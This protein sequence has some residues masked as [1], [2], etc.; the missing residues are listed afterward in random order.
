V[1][2]VEDSG[3]GIDA[4]F[5]PH[6]FD[7]FS[8]EDSSSIRVHGGLGLGLAIVRDLVQLHGGTVEVESLGDKRGATFTV[9]LP[10]KSDQKMS[11]QKEK[12]FRSPVNIGNKAVRLDGIRVLIVD[13]EANAREASIELLTFHGAEVK[14][15]S[16]A[17]E[18]F[19][20]FN[21]FKPHIL[22]SDIAMPGEDGYSLIKKVRALSKV[23]GGNTPAVA[24]TAYAGQEDSHQAL[25]AGFQ[26][27]LS[28]PVDGDDFVNSIAKLVGKNIH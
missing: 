18:G 20:V 25:S 5:L 9:M 1:I 24:M 17:K 26:L 2:R 6:I 12:A 11:A 14:S 10:I 13:D 3:K 27:H 23:A 16:S 21:Q 4:E 8:Q 15:A 19:N 28:K 22:V 7:R